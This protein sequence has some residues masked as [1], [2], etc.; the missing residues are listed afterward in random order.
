MV[1]TGEWRYHAGFNTE[2]NTY[3]FEKVRGYFLE[4]GNFH[5]TMYVDMQTNVLTGYF[6]INNPVLKRENIW[7]GYEAALHSIEY[8]IQQ[9]KQQLLEEHLAL[10]VLSKSLT[11]QFN[12]EERNDGRIN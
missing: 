10:T 1:T 9:K 12:N 2:N 4:D 7:K 11:K 3:F 6:D 8:Q 5:C